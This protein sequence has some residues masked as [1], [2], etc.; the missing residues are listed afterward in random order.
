MIK[1][2]LRRA[3]KRF[4]I[5]AFKRSSNVYIPEEETYRIVSE[6]AGCSAP[7]VIDGGAPTTVSYISNANPIP[8]DKNEI[9]VCT[10]MAGEMLGKRGVV[11]TVDA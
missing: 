4:G 7:V 11:E 5:V 2:L 3:L 10:A 8:S 9:A 1:K 6:L